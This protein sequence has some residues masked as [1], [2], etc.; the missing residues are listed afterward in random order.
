M[1]ALMLGTQRSRAS[2]VNSLM[3]NTVP[4]PKMPGASFFTLW[5]RYIIA[6]VVIVVLCVNLH[7]LLV[8]EWTEI[9][10]KEQTAGLALCFLLR[11]R[12]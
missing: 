9:A 7:L 11:N 3:E 8:L 6:G 1:E 10:W 4:R 12:Q 5:G 2:S